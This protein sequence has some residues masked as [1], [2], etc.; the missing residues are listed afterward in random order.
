MTRYDFGPN[1]PMAP[2]RLELTMRL[3]H[4]LGVLDHLDVAKPAGTG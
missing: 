3:A 4:E 2:L 1:H